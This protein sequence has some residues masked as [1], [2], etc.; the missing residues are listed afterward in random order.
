MTFGHRDLIYL[1]LILDDGEILWEARANAGRNLEQ[2]GRYEDG[3]HLNVE[4]YFA[5]NRTWGLIIWDFDQRREIVSRQGTFEASA[6]EIL[7][8]LI[9][10]DRDFRLYLRAA[11]QRGP[12]RVFLD[13][14]SMLQ[15]DAEASGFE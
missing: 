15:L 4:M 13:E 7:Y 9:D 10:D 2:V 8:Q 3:A 5:S 12:V 6:P 1:L 14:I 11:A